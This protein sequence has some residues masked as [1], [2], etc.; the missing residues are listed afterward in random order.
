M[1]FYNALG[2][3]PCVDP[4]SSV[5]A[6]DMVDKKA[7]VYEAVNKESRKNF[8]VGMHNEMVGVRTPAAACFVCFKPADEGGEFLLLDGRQMFRD[9]D[10]G[11][12][13]TLVSK[14][15]QYAV[16]ELPMGFLDKLPDPLKE[17]ALP[18]AKWAAGFAVDAKVDF[19]VDLDWGESD[20]DGQR[21]LQVR[22]KTQ[23]PV[24]R[25]P[26][27][28]VP[29]WFCNIHSH[30]Q[31]LREEREKVYGA[32]R[33]E[34]GASRINKSDVTYGDGSRIPDEVSQ[35][36]DD[37]TMKNLQYVKM[38]HGDVVLLDNYSALHGRNVFEGT[39]KHA[40]T[41]FENTVE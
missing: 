28:G 9:F 25:H 30:S 16:A 27:T 33:F 18:A 3:K 22:A 29:V 12:L 11:V 10:T 21:V 1:Q 5:A 31:F 32:E 4:L 35:Q 24:V 34:S 14:Q 38:E 37:L 41:W 23:P 2:F 26:V 7:G 17:V 20:Y 13:D 40:V 8:F 15:I 39:R 19:E 6:R 36:I